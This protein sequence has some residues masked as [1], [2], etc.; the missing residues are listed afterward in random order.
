MRL[1][2]PTIL[3]WQ[4]TMEAIDIISKYSGIKPGQFN[5][6]GTKDKRA[7][8]TQ[9]ISIHKVNAEK[10]ANVNSKLR[11]MKMGN[12]SYSKVCGGGYLPPLDRSVYVVLSNEF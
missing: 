6:A 9:R 8:T 2:T 12:F 5:Y 11:G 3:I 1:D 4:G 7:K 10:L